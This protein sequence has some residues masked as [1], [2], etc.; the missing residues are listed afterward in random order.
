MPRASQVDLHAELDYAI[1]GDAEVLRGGS[2][3]SRD[4]REERLSPPEHLAV[5]RRE[6][7]LAPEKVAR[8]RRD[9]RNAVVLRHDA[10]DLG[11][12]RRLHEPVVGRD[13]EEAATE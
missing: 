9:V 6:K 11:N 7:G 3:V 8:S 4:E 1:R 13:L 2:C 5:A 10:H 12:V